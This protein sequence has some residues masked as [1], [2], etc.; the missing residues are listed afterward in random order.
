MKKFLKVLIAGMTFLGLTIPAHSAEVAGVDIHG[1]ISQGYLKTS[2]NN[3]LAQTEDGTFEFN[4][5]GINFSKELTD[6]MRVGLQLFS[7]DLGDYGNNEV[8]IDWAYGDYRWKDWL[9]VRAGKLKA[10]HG[11][12]NETRDV[13]M[14]RNSIFLP[15]SVYPDVARD[16]MLNLIGAGLYGNVDMGWFGGLNY[17]AQIGTQN[18]ESNE[19]LAQ[20][21]KGVVWGGTEVWNREI[22]VDD[23][24]V[25]G[26]TWDTPLDGLRF[27]G[28]YQQINIDMVSDFDFTQSPIPFYG[29]GTFYDD[30]KSETYV[31][32]AEYTWNNLLLAAEYMWA[33]RDLKYV[34]GAGLIHDVFK[35]D[36]W[37]VQAAYRFTDWFELGAY[38]SEYYADKNMRD[39]KGINP[40]TGLPYYMPS[41]RAYLKDICLTTRFDV[42]EYMV[43]KLEGH[44]MDGTNQLS[45]N[46]NPLPSDYTMD[47]FYTQFEKDWYMYAAKVTFSF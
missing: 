42:N 43:I 3:Y 22:N 6:K 8:V 7:K 1:F 5:F 38:Y 4:E 14:L 10:P 23:K 33:K 41:D 13:D 18:I 30:L 37:Y 17:Q 16:A 26:L 21:L 45:G 39:G 29:A 11:L 12:Y 27:G 20:T 31:V 28:T 32:S 9:G 25:L 40:D 19:N 15:Q 44:K 24:Y 46:Q 34:T 36:G 47:D 35:P 2:D